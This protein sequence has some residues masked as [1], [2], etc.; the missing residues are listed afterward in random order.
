MSNTLLIA[1]LILAC[2]LAPTGLV[3][4]FI[5]EEFRKTRA[6]IQD[7]EARLRSRFESLEGEFAHVRL[8]KFGVFSTKLTRKKMEESD[9]HWTVMEIQEVPND[10]SD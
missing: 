2:W 9:W 10:N 4:W 8:T 1:L 3:L 5:R 6:H 7:M